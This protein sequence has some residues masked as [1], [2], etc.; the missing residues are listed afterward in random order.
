MHKDPQFWVQDHKQDHKGSRAMKIESSVQKSH[1]SG[2]PLSSSVG[3]SSPDLSN[4]KTQA[5]TS[6]N[7]PSDAAETLGNDS[8]EINH[9]TAAHQSP[10]NQVSFDTQ[11]SDPPAPQE[12]HETQNQGADWESTIS[13]NTQD[14]EKI[15]EFIHEIENKNI[16]SLLDGLQES[17]DRARKQ[18]EDSMRHYY[19]KERPRL[20]SMKEKLNEAKATEAANKTSDTLK[21]ISQVAGMIADMQ[22]DLSSS[23]LPPE[24]RNAIQASLVQAQKLTE[25]RAH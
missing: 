14:I 7:T 4:T 8:T 21:N 5:E 18:M 6:S 10:P 15:Q 16:Q 13:G 22:R 3:S 9:Q 1:Y 2:Q 12:P 17:L 25:M 11:P 23:G 20:D 19:E 24:Q